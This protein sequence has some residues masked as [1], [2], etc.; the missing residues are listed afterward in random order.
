[1]DAAIARIPVAVVAPTRG[2]AN[3]RARLIEQIKLP[4]GQDLGVCPKTV[5][6]QLRREIVAIFIRFDLNFEP[7]LL[8][9]RLVAA[10]SIGRGQGKL[11]NIFKIVTDHHYRNI[12]FSNVQRFF[13]LVVLIFS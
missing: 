9:A 5:G 12:S 3:G 7:A 13:L 1:M 6:E 10:R 8:V 4:F 2:C 11:G